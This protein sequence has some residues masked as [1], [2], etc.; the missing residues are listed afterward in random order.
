[1]EEELCDYTARPLEFLS[2]ADPLIFTVL[3]YLNLK[4]CEIVLGNLKAMASHMYYFPL[5]TDAKTH[6]CKILDNRLT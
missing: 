3:L 4:L 6:Y 1:L 5:F 2:S